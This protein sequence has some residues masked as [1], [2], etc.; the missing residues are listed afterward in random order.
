MIRHEPASRWIVV[1]GNG[2]PT[3]LAFVE[4]GLLVSEGED[5]FFLYINTTHEPV[6]LA[7]ENVFDTE[8]GARERATALLQN[9]IS[10]A[11]RFIAE[12]SAAL[13]KLQLSPLTGELGTVPTRHRP[14]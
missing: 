6:L 2:Q 8:E 9:D 1:H 4:E 13:A 7:A 12:R 10:A 11:N 3:I 14:N 5:V